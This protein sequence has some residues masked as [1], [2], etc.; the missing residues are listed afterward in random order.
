M[1]GQVEDG[2]EYPS[3]VPAT[4]DDRVSDRHGPRAARVKDRALRCV[5]GQ[6]YLM[7]HLIS[8]EGTI[9]FSGFPEPIGSVGSRTS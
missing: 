8:H 1:A 9:Y 3:S 2:G 5:H 6:V 7:G 4:V